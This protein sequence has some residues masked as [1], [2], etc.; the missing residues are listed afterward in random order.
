MSK[1]WTQEQD[2]ELIDLYG[3]NLSFG[4]IAHRLGRTRNAV[5]GRARRLKLIHPEK[6][7]TTLQQQVE[8]LR[9]RGWSF[10]KIEEKLGQKI[11]LSIKDVINSRHREFTFK[12]PKNKKKPTLYFS[13][14]DLAF[15]KTLS[16]LGPDD[17][18]FPQGDGPFLFCG[19][20]TNGRGPYCARCRSIAYQT[21][22][23]TGGR[24]GKIK[25]ET[26]Q[27]I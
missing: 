6:V 5:A 1:Q 14:V 16:D 11:D 22:S 21:S 15:T 18:R 4:F 20:K 17:C 12:Q 25:S 24:I 23:K 8:D 26:S 27:S 7:H 10:S 3:S 13:K 2:N 9:G 19:E